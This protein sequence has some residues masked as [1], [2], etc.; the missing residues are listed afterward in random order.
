MAIVHAAAR[1]ATPRN[2]ICPRKLARLVDTRDAECNHHAGFADG[3]GRGEI[4]V[5]PIYSPNQRRI[6]D[7]CVAARSRAGL[8]RHAQRSSRGTSP[9]TCSICLPQP[10]YV[11]F[12]QWGHSTLRHML[13]LQARGEIARCQ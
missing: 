11:G 7:G 10:A 9:N 1:I 4:D 3:S 12:L 8:S 6:F 13:K 5:G 2:P